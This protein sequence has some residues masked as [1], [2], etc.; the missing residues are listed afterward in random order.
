MLVILVIIVLVGLGVATASL[1]L[2]ERAERRSTVAQLEA[3]RRVVEPQ[4]PDP[5][6][7]PRVDRSP[8]EVAD[9]PD[10]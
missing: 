6:I 5:R 9:G 8:P 7:D 1:V 4:R 3:L 10:H 2:R